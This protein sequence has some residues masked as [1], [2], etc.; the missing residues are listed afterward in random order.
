MGKTSSWENST[1]SPI[2][3]SRL[4]QPSSWL[5]SRPQPEENTRPTWKQIHEAKC[6]R[7]KGRK[8]SKIRVSDFNAVLPISHWTYRQIINKETKLEHKKWTKY[9]PPY[10]PTYL[11]TTQ[12]MK[13]IHTESLSGQ[14]MG[15]SV[16]QIAS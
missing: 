6:D 16:R 14:P 8:S 11:S 5:L 13:A 7:N 12:A 15:F 4:R 9:L 3:R 10:L 2:L 1:E